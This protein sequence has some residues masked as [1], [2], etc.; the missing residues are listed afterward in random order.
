MPYQTRKQKERASLHKIN[1]LNLS[2]ENDQVPK[3]EVTKVNPSSAPEINN[4]K[5]SQ[6]IGK[7]MILDLTKS[8][9]LIVIIFSIQIGI[10]VAIQ[11]NLIPSWI[12]V[13]R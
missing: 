4:V 6:S 11:S 9:T 5:M 1:R 10:Y 13:P 12:P 8:L 3:K 7:Y 2:W